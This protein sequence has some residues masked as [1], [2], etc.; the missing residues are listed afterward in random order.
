VRPGVQ[1]Y[2]KNYKTTYGPGGLGT[3]GSVGLDNYVGFASGCKD[4]PVGGVPASEM[5]SDRDLSLVKSVR[6]LSE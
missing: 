6:H 5:P 3:Y 1:I 2:T 4:A